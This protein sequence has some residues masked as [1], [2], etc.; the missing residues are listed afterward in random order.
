MLGKSWTYL[1][2][3][4]DFSNKKKIFKKVILDNPELLVDTLRRYKNKSA[5]PYNF[6]NDPKEEFKWHDSARCYASQ[7][8]LKFPNVDNI[9]GQEIATIV[10]KHFEK[11]IISGLACDFHYQKSRD[12]KKEEIGQLILL[13][14]LECYTKNTDLDVRYDHKTDTI[15]LYKKGL[16]NDKLLL[17]DM[18][19]KFSSTQKVNEYYTELIE[20]SNRNLLFHDVA[21]IIVRTNDGFRVFRDLINLN[22]DRNKSEKLKFFAIDGGMIDRVSWRKINQ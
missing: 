18:V 8:P 4:K 14:L 21:F 22:N 2:T 16:P 5:R 9:S 1:P 15:S 6:K 10:I 11:L 13:E 7:F 19:L 12:P 17:L 3:L 20:K